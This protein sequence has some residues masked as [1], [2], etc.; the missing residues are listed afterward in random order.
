VQDASRLHHHHVEDPA[1]VSS[2]QRTLAMV[3]LCLCALTTAVDIT[4]TNVAL[5]FIGRDLHSSVAGLQWVIDAYNIVLAGLLVLGGGL[6]DR[7]GRRKVFLGGYSL[8][9]L[10][11]LLAALSSSTGA[12]IAARAVMGVGAAAVIAPALAI[13][14]VLYPPAERGKAI[15]LWAVFGA[16]GLAIGPVVGG[17]LLA[18]FWWGS[19][20]IVNVPI[21]AVGVVVGLRVIPES[22][23]PEVGGLDVAGALLS[24]S[25]L[26]ALVFGVIEGPDRGWSS[27]V[28]I[29]AVLAGVVL[30]GLFVLREQR[31]PEP[32]FDVGILRRPVVAAG[33]ATLFISYVVFTGMLFVIPQ[34]LENVQ[35]ESVVTVGL[36][37]V[38]FAAVFGVASMRSAAV[39]Q[40]LGARMTVSG[41]LA[42]C[43]LGIA[44]VAVFQ[45]S[46]VTATIAATA[47]VGIGLSGLIAPASTVVMNNL[48]EAKAG[49]GS[50]LNMV[51]R[52]VG[53]AVGVAAVGSILSSVYRDHLGGAT[54]GLSEANADTAHGSLQGALR[55]AG[56]LPGNADH[57]LTASAR[58]A[59]NAGG[60]VGYV[61][62]AVIAAA[63]AAWVW[64]ALR[65]APDGSAPV[66]NTAGTVAT[67]TTPGR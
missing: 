38:P 55:V 64:R 44:G 7:Y 2:G 29:V 35:G 59:F 19:V 9:G 10:S 66:T 21:V 46:S 30:T 17:L 13:V 22:R 24:V 15:A 67:P 51:S 1:D 39:M 6:A 53:A 49:D 27:P 47:I 57:Q 42:I 8:F 16:A 41:G 33:A 58:D 62:T 14:A 52:F 63:G 32:L 4:I 20:F 37:L 26:G 11:C 48:P 65:P 5:P 31:A 43:A 23:K 40:R 60:R 28:V 34:W 36:L 25:G 54:A 56:G 18:H 61:V 12:L 45:D 3:V 50:S